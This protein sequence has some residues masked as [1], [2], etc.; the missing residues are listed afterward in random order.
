MRPARA[1][2]QHSHNPGATYLAGSSLLSS[3]WCPQTQVSMWLW[4]QGTFSLHVSA[5]PRS[6]PVPQPPPNQVPR[7]S[8]ENPHTLQVRQSPDGDFISYT[9]KT[10]S[11][12]LPFPSPAPKLHTQSERNYKLFLPSSSP[13]K[14]KIWLMPHLSGTKIQHPP[15]HPKMLMHHIPSSG[16]YTPVSN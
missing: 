16:E 8:Q 13:G 3:A 6:D 10:I 5:R 9:I 7:H 11:N 1:K 4:D 12:F 14:S 15:P 2:A